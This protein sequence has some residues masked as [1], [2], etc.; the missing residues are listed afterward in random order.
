MLEVCT[1]EKTLI[2]GNPHKGDGC[3]LKLLRNEAITETLGVLL[4]IRV[5]VRGDT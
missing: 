1:G 4:R 3:C 2:D 5:R